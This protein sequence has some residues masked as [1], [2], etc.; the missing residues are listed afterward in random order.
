MAVKTIGT[1]NLVERF[2]L[3]SIDG[4]TLPAS[5]KLV[6]E[7]GDLLLTHHSEPEASN[8]SASVEI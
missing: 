4:F 1:E 5:N 7:H 8:G 6:D 2:E 3:R